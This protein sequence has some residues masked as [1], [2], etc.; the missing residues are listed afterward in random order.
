MLLVCVQAPGR[1]GVRDGDRCQQQRN[2]GRARI[3]GVSGVV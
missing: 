1:R 3:G 2:A